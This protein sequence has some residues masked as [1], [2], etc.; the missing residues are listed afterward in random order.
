MLYLINA[1]FVRQHHARL[2]FSSKILARW[3]C[4]GIFRTQIGECIMHHMSAPF[5]DL[6]LGKCSEC[7][8]A[9]IIVDVKCT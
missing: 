7:F 4:L 6:D 5:K 9:D 3:F 1:N 2:T 8:S